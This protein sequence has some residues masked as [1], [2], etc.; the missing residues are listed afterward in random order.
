MTQI[1][2]YGAVEPDAVAALQRSVQSAVAEAQRVGE[3]TKVDILRAQYA[4]IGKEVTAK[5]YT[6]KLNK[7]HPALCPCCVPDKRMPFI[8]QN[9]GSTKAPLR[10]AHHPDSDPNCKLR[11]DEPEHSQAKQV[12]AE[13][14]RR[15][16]LLDPV[17][18]SRTIQFFR[19]VLGHEGGFNAEAFQRLTKENDKVS[20]WKQTEKQDYPFKLMMNGGPYQVSGIDGGLHSFGFRIITLRTPQ[21]KRF[22][23]RPRDVRFYAV[24]SRGELSTMF[25]G[26]AFDKLDK[27]QNEQQRPGIYCNTDKQGKQYIRV[28]DDVVRAL[29]QF[30][31]DDISQA[32]KAAGN[33]LT[34][35]QQPVLKRSIHACMT[36]VMER[37]ASQP[38]RTRSATRAKATP[39]QAATT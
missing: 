26:K 37:V 5:T 2:F 6:T 19:S 23:M 12:I 28:T 39:R 21:E 25:P 32:A 35:I 18:V 4:A 20:F 13:Q 1:A 29:T 3:Y 27:K 11:A 7:G 15:E 33:E 9:E 24:D 8:V 17:I 22:N 36:S 10:F 34:R 38:L 16:C 31:L 14:R 30:T